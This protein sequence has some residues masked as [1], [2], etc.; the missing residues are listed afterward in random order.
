MSRIYCSF[1]L[2]TVHGKNSHSPGLTAAL[3]QLNVMGGGPEEV[4]LVGVTPDRDNQETC[5]SAAVQSALPGLL[6]MALAELAK[7]G[8]VPKKKKA[9]CRE[10]SGGREEPRLS[11]V[12]TD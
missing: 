8:V 12:K 1:S 11:S 4:T 9:P 6:E 10:I 7:H 3:L 5:L 2:K